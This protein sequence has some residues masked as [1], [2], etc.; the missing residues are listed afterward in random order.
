MTD[1]PNATHPD[2]SLGERLQSTYPL[3][4]IVF[5]Y[6]DYKDLLSASAVSKPWREV[7]SNERRKRQR[8]SWFSCVEEGHFCKLNRGVDLLRNNPRLCVA[9]VNCSPDQELRTQQG[10]GDS[11]GATGTNLQAYQS[12]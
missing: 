12:T 6:L 11:D 7:A 8:C 5:G 10:D 2:F 3:L 9:L 1:S 4:H